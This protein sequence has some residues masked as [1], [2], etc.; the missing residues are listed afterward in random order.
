M[1]EEFSINAGSLIDAD[2][3]LLDVINGMNVPVDEYGMFIGEFKV[4][5]EYIEVNNKG[6]NLNG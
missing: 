5:I 4:T 1:K 2:E 6:E 3:I